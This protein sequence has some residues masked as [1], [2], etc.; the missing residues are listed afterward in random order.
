MQRNFYHLRNVQHPCYTIKNKL[1]LMV[2]VH[3]VYWKLQR[4]ELMFTKNKSHCATRKRSNSL[5]FLPF[6][7]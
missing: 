6:A 4:N 3:T 5:A 7:Y 2:N 1:F